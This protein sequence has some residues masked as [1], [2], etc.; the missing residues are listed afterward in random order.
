LAFLRVSILDAD[1]AAFDIAEIA[2]A[3][4]ERLAHHGQRGQQEAAA[5]HYSMT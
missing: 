4:E 1:I 3:L 2:Q 5:V